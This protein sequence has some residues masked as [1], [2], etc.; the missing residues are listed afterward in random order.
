MLT[1]IPN[2]VLIVQINRFSHQLMSHHIAHVTYKSSQ[3]IRR[4][5][6]AGQALCN[7]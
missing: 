1:H 7:T 3:H 5:L 6:L 4:M 2:Q